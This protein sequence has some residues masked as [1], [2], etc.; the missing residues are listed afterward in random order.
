MEQLAQVY[1]TLGM[2]KVQTYIQSGNV[3]FEHKKTDAHKLTN[4]IQNQIRKSFGFEVVVILRTG[5]EFRSLIKKTPFDKRDPTKLYV[6]F[7]SDLHGN[8][9]IEEISGA[10]GK[11]EEYSVSGKEVYLYCPNGYGRTKL[12]NNFFEDKLGVAATTRNW[13]TVNTLYSMTVRR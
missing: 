6:A 1:E 3:I 7:L 8:V 10:R 13:N 12:T 2:E 9:P 4:E 5:N 11:G